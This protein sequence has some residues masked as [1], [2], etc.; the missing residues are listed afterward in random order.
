MLKCPLVKNAQSFPRDDALVFGGRAFSW[1]LLNAYVAST[2]RHL[3][4]IT[5]RPGMRVVVVSGNTPQAV[6][7]F[8]SFWRAGVTP[9]I[10][11]PA[12]PADRLKAIIILAGSKF[13]FVP[14]D[15]SRD[16]GRWLKD[17]DHPVKVVSID[18]AIN[19]QFSGIFFSGEKENAVAVD[20]DLEAAVV[21]TSGSNGAPKGAR[22]TY[23]NLFRNAEGAQEAI[24]FGPR[25]R[26]LITLPFFH[27]SGLSI[28]FRALF[29][30]GGMVLPSEE[31]DGDLLKSCQFTHLSLVPTQLAR[32]L[33]EKRGDLPFSQWKAV[34]LGGAPVPGLLAREAR[35]RGV[36]LFITYGMTET[37]SQIATSGYSEDNGKWARVLP[38]R[39]VVLASDG[40]IMVR[41]DVVFKGYLGEPDRKSTDWFLTGDIGI[42]KDNCITVVGRKDRMFI[43][44]GENVHPEVPEKVMLGHPLVSCAVVAAREDRDFG[45][46]GVMFIKMTDEETLTPERV[47]EFVAY[48]K[49]RLRPCEVPKRLYPWPEDIPC[50]GKTS[51]SFLMKCLQEA[52]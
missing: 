8:L 50:S 40:E 4:E 49:D 2:A 13:V 52:R 46:V 39:E 36:N 31:L 45:R 27:V 12:T 3:K 29:S 23:G 43:S 10:L 9:V 16:Y 25:D 37:A 18:E 38:F 47:I 5:L 20:P 42:M 14:E 7:L 24:P 11:D 17:A 35:E 1:E 6:I 22:L 48:L 33:R 44:G 51:Y 19:Y 21:F 30:G 34:L 32:L 26:W 41:G 15:R 28:I